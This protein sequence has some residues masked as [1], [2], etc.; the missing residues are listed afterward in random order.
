MANITFFEA[1]KWAF[2]FIKQ[3]DNKHQADVMLLLQ[4]QM[5]WTKVQLL[6]NYQT[7]MTV[8]D[9]EYFKRNVEKYCQDWPVQYLLGYADFFDLRL[10]VT[11]A[12]LI[13]R[14]E[15]QDLVEWILE[16]E[17]AKPQKVLDLGTG[18]GAIGLALKTQRPQWQ[19]TLSDL[20][21]EALTI[22]KENALALGLTCQYVVSDV[23]DAFDNQAKYDILISNPP[24]IADDEV[25]YMDV[26]VLK[27]EPHSALFAKNQGLAI[28]QKIAKQAPM[29]LTKHGR[30]YLE[31]GFKQ[32]RAVSDIFT[33]LY[34]KAKIEVKQDLSGHDR[35]V[36]VSF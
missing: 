35:M 36:K 14:P 22:A 30:I 26:S 4:S 15:T 19:I 12:T 10:K 5:N 25:K 23:L 8:K 1:Q 29:H 2:S 17:E 31:I 18:S 20:M 33:R 27:Y 7:Q 6:T 21:P 9:W 13:P 3:F 24:Y 28:Y 32:A 16:T 11:Q 34:P